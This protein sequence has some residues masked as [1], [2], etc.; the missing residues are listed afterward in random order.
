M[1]MT[2][3]FQFLAVLKSAKFGHLENAISGA[4]NFFGSSRF[5]GS[6]RLSLLYNPC[7]SVFFS[8]FFLIF[9]DFVLKSVRFWPPYSLR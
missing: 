3:L 8:D 4:K 7:S 2:F 1:E 5:R 9:S 6:T